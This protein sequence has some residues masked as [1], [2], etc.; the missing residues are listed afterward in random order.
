MRLGGELITPLR[1]LAAAALV[2]VLGGLGLLAHYL[3]VSMQ[4]SAMDA[5]LKANL[6]TIDQVKRVR[7]LYTEGVVQRALAT[8][9]LTPSWDWRQ[10]SDGIPLPAT[11]VKEISE[12]TAK[13][14]DTTLSLVSPYPWPHRAGREMDLFERQAWDAFRIDPD[15]VMTRQETVGGRRVLRVAV[16]DKMTS[17]TCVDCHNSDPLSAKRDWAV[18]DVRAVFETTRVV[19]PYLQ[20]AEARAQKLLSALA[21]AGAVACGAIIVLLVLFER[22]DRAKRKADEAAYHLAEHDALTGLKNRRRLRAEIDACFEAPQPSRYAALLLIDLDGFK[23]INDTYGH[24]A[25]DSLLV[26]VADRLR[27]VGHPRDMLARLGGDEFALLMSGSSAEPAQLERLAGH[28]C[29]AFGEPFRIDGR[30]VTIGGCVGWARLWIDAGSTADLMTAADL[31]LYAAKAQ[32]RAQARAFDPSMM[33][34]ALRRAQIG[35]ALRD[36]L[37]SDALEL[38]YQPIVDAQDGRTISFEALMRWP[39]GDGTFTPPAEF[40]PLAEEI[41]LIAPLGAWALRRACRDMAAFDDTTRVSVNLSSKQ[42]DHEHLLT[43]VREALDFSGLAPERLDLEITES[44]LL[45]EDKRTLATIEGLRAMG[46]G[47]ALD[48]FGTGYSCLSYL[49]D[50]PVTALKIDRS[51]VSPLGTCANATPLVEAIVGLARALRLR[52]VAE[53][54]ETPEQAQ[55]L[56]ALGCD[57]LQGYWFSRPAPLKT[58]AHKSETAREGAARRA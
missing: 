6:E 20:D 27:R 48:D 9:A 55:A 56:R 30:S 39:R 50:Y 16:A 32:G 40:I 12:L 57:S 53:G 22:S 14:G 35:L 31:A 29:R 23:P 11:L 44:L 52:T 46:I 7:G 15:R 25:G 21:A 51:F 42:L 58:F 45:R 17:Q 18:G 26:Q 3:P 19:E 37:A 2:V 36:A 34:A 33:I 24:G 47:V 1:A 5:A 10:R 43:E 8:K 4:R 13:S 28:I 54:V 38:H 49:R 41:G